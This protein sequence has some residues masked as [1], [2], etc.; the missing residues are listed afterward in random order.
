MVDNEG[1]GLWGARLRLSNGQ[2][3]IT[4]ND[5]EFTISTRLANDTLVANLQ[6]YNTRSVAINGH[7]ELRISLEESPQAVSQVEVDLGTVKAGMHTLPEPLGGWKS[8]EAYIKENAVMPNGETGRVKLSFIVTLKG[9]ISNVKVLRG[10]NEAMNQKA[11]ELVK[12]GPRWEPGTDE[13]GRPVRL[14]IRFRKG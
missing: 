9:E 13:G 11:V 14:K 10:H 7:Q 3:V 6:G 12:N 1:Q 4:D 2:E 8:Y 5:G